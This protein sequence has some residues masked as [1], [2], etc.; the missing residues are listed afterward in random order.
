MLHAVCGFSLLVLTGEAAGLGAHRDA[1]CA[2]RLAGC[3]SGSACWCWPRSCLGIAPRQ[4]RVVRRRASG[5]RCGRTRLFAFGVARLVRRGTSSAARCGPKITD[6]ERRAVLRGRRRRSTVGARSPTAPK[7]SAA[8]LTGLAGGSRRFSGSHEVGVVRACVDAGGL[9]DQ[10]H[11]RRRRRKAD[12]GSLV[13]GGRAVDIAELRRLATP[14]ESPP[15]IA[16]AAGRARSRGTQCRCR[17]SWVAATARPGRP[18]AS[19]SPRPP[20]TAGSSRWPTPTGSTSPSATAANRSCVTT[21]RPSA[22]SPPG[23]VVRGGSSG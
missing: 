18:A 7:R 16:P 11:V 14:V 17:P 6:L 19:T 22:S 10:R 12:D 3:R 20:A 13:V 23:V 21:A 8:R 4:R 5:R 9:V 15:S 1:P 2:G